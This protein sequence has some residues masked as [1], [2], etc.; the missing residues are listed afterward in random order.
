M[1]VRLLILCL[2][3]SLLTSCT[4]YFQEEP[5]QKMKQEAHTSPVTGETTYSYRPSDEPAS[6]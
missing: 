3:A 6:R 4:E 2:G 5:H 1:L